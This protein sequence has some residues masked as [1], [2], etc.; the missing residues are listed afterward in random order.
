[1]SKLYLFILVFLP[2]TVISQT[3]SGKVYDA[4]ATVNGAKIINLTQN[5]MVYADEEGNFKIEASVNDQIAF[6]TLFHEPLIIL[7]TQKDFDDDMVIELKKNVNELDKVY[8]NKINEKKFESS[9][10]EN[11]MKTQIKKDIELHPYLY[12]PPPNTNMDFMAI[13]GLI[14]KLFKKRK[15]EEPIQMAEYRELQTLF[16]TDSFF[17]AQFLSSELNIDKEYHPLFLEFC[18]AKGIDKTLLLKE[19]QLPLID[20]IEHY[21]LEFLDLIQ[22]Y[23]E[24]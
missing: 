12:S 20:T 24:D 2:V 7:I 8:L 22:D 18:E 15:V 13:A 11:Q 23:K 16:E 14:T 5:F 10:V 9:K 4:E 3:V 21:S 17:N 1:L 19:N 6:T